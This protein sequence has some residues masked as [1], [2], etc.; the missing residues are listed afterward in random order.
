MPGS[1]KFNGTELA[2]VYDRYAKTMYSHFQK[3]MMQIPCETDSTSKYSLV[4]DC[5]DCK[6][7]YKNWLCTVS[8]PRC[9]DFT[10]SSGSAIIRNA[11]QPFPNGSMLPD[12]EIEKY[13]PFSYHNNSRNQFIDKEIAPGPYKEVLPC[14]D[15]CYEVVQSCPASIGFK[16]PRP[17][18]PGFES[19]YGRRNDQSDVVSCNAP[20]EAR[21]RF[22]AATTAAP[23][24]LL[25]AILPSLTLV[26]TLLI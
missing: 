21:T 14:E 16:C 24:P 6:R 26:M 15:L 17:W 12:K 10:S 1:D 7:A 5:D 23:Q 4:R 13:S 9:E 20:G 19:S 25:L 3:I 11:G 22:S 18:Y 2:Q 8:I